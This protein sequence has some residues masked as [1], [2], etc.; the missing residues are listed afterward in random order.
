MAHHDVP[1]EP[2]EIRIIASILHN[3][4]QRWMAWPTA[5]VLQNWLVLV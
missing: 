2:K 5:S 3:H 4:E 1:S